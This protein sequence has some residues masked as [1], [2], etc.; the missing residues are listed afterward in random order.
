MSLSAQFD[1][2]LDGSLP[3]DPALWDAEAY[4]LFHFGGNDGVGYLFLC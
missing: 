2:A 3:A 4:K 1:A